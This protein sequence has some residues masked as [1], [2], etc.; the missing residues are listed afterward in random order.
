MFPNIVNIGPITLH[1][2]GLLLAVAFLVGLKVASYYAKKDS[3]ESSRIVDLVIYI[4][5][6]ALIGAK[7]LHVIVDFDYYRQD[8]SRLLH[9][10]QVGGVYYG[11]FLF[12]VVITF[13]YVRRHH[14][15]FWRTADSLSMGLSIGQMFGRL[16]C[17]L[18]GC[19]WGIEAQPGFPFAVTFSNPLAAEQVGT[20]LNIPLHPAQL[21]EAAGMLLIFLILVFTFPHRRFAGQQ[22]FLYM[23]LYSVLRFNVEFFRG[24]PRGTVFNGMLS[25]SQLISLIVFIASLG[26]LLTRSRSRAAQAV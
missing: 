25:T 16:G 21:Y 13:W 2:Y 5:I 24:D 22:F 20:P 23:L 19:C 12:A 17:F 18:A 7:L 26:I 1:S 9:I 8:W 11:G 14:L 15:N 3:L 6:A 4:F 10:Y